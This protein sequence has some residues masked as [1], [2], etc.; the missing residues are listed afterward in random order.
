MRL[1]QA[2]ALHIGDRPIDRVMLGTTEVWRRIITIT[3]Q[4]PTFHD[5]DPWIT[6]PEQEGVTYTVD[7]TP[8]Y[9]QTVIVT[10]TAVAGYEL[11]GTTTWEHT[12]GPPPRY[13]ASDSGS[14]GNVNTTGWRTITTHV[15]AGAG[16]PASGTWR[17]D[18]SVSHLD[19]GVRVLLDG[20]A[21]TTYGPSRDGNSR[22]SVSIPE[23]EY[24][25]G[26][27]LTFQGISSSSNTSVPS[28]S[29]SLS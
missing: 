4:A 25:P 20:A 5:G 1:D 9:S 6:L 19:K 28:W 27:Q 11:A 10:A 16:G 24:A 17:V 26:Q 14:Y 13:T 23:R 8:D 15:I 22:Q 7:G 18:W 12:Y 21:I 3:P 29:W 2:D